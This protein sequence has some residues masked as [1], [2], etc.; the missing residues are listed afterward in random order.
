MP[1]SEQRETTTRE[2]NAIGMGK[3]SR[4]ATS[5]RGKRK[6]KKL[7]EVSEE[8]GFDQ[9]NPWGSLKVAYE[10]A[11]GSTISP[12]S[13]PRGPEEREI[14]AGRRHGDGF[15]PENEAGR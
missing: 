14:V 8:A 11:L 6:R 15:L 2:S 7:A 5:S 1:E 12:K 13:G 9:D 4:P 10:D 3:G